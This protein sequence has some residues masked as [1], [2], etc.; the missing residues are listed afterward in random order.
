MKNKKIIVLV[1]PS[2]SGKTSIGQILDTKGVPRL[3]T[4]TTRKARLGEVDGTDYYFRDFTEAD[5]ADFVEQTVY[6]RNRYGLTKAEVESMLEKHDVV[7]VSLDQQG[8][9]ALKAAYP[10][11]A[12]I[13][14]IKITE[15]EMVERMEKRGDSQAQ[16]DER[17]RFC[18]NTRELLPPEQTDL[19]IRNIDLEDSA[20]IILDELAKQED[21]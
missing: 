20:Q 17:I 10:E 4:T 5:M 13:V 7:H 2:G 11:E 12:Y 18:R 15:E 16:I 21:S 19:I 1:G 6:N 8:A 9:D 14:F 3:V